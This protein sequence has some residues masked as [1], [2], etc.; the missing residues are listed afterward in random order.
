LDLTMA[1]LIHLH[2]DAHQEAQEL[3]PWYVTGQIDP[4]DRARLEAHLADCAGCQA[5]VRLEMRL[6]QEVAA[7]PMELELGWLDLRQR[8]HIR[9]SVW[10]RVKSQVR[11]LWNGL[12]SGDYVRWA[13][14]G[15][16]ALLLLL[17]SIV[18]A[19]DRAAPYHTLASPDVTRPGNVIV[20]FRPETAERRL[21]HALEAAGARLVDGPT[22]AGAYLLFVNPDRRPAALAALRAD[23]DILMAEPLDQESPQ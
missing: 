3:L 11:N 18:S 8:L 10:S 19:P 6:S 9:P 17:V 20:M 16:M 13:V 1:D 15:Q 2:S 14:A 4:A 21:R 12:E 5:E 23:G 7:L 22:P